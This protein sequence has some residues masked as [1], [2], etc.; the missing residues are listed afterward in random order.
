MTL[1]LSLFP[2]IDLLGRGFEQAGFCVVRGPD[3]LW[4]GDIFDFHAPAGKFTGIIGGSPCQK[5]SKANRT[6]RDMGEGMRLAYEFVRVVEE[7]EPDWFLL[8]NVPEVQTVSARG[9]TV[10]RFAL[11]SR[12][13][14]SVQNRNR[15]FQFG[16]RIGEYITPIRAETAVKRFGQRTAF[17]SEGRRA[18]R[19]LWPDFCELQGLPRDFDLPGWSLDA[20]YSAVGNGVHVG[21]AYAIAQAIQERKP[22]A[23]T[24][25]CACRCGRV[26]T[27]RRGQRTATASCRSRYRYQL[28]STQSPG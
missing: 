19:R 25:L 14:G 8:E 4:G 3:I 6:N 20:K 18:E 11:N 12:E 24:R 5:I 13:V 15:H 7:A 23:D 22:I 16:S 21:V 9:Y 26:L 10:Q 1:I 17:A 27:G 28:Q 2:G